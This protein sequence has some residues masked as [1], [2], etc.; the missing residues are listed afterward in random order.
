LLISQADGLGR[1]IRTEWPCVWAYRSN[2]EL[3]QMADN[4][5]PLRYVTVK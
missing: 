1:Q 3:Q 2:V 5:F 4:Y